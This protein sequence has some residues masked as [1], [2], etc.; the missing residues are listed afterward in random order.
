MATLTE[1]ITQELLDGL[2]DPGGLDRVLQ[3]YQ[4]SKGPL[5][6]ALAY[7][8]DGAETL[9]RSVKEEL[10]DV[11][12]GRETAQADDGRLR[13]ERT[14][15]EAELQDLESRR[16][17]AAEQL[18]ALEPT[19]TGAE[20][21]ERWGFGEA[22]LARLA[23]LLG[24]TAAEQG[25]PPEDGVAQFFETIR[26]YER[27]VSWDLEAT[28]AES[29]AVQ[30]R[31]ESQRWEAEARAR[32][33]KTKLRSASI[34][35][36]ERL[37][38]LGVKE[39]DLL[40][41]EMVMQRSGE[42]AEDVTESLERYG[43]LSVAAEE[44]EERLG[45]IKKEVAKRERQLKGLNEEREGVHAA[46]EAVRADALG[47]VRQ[48]GQQA[49]REVRNLGDRAQEYIGGLVVAAEDYGKLRGD[50][51]LLHEEL[52]IARALRSDDIAQWQALTLRDIRLLVTGAFHW[53]TAE[54]RDTA[55]RLT[56]RLRRVLG[57][58][59]YTD[60]HLSQLLAGAFLG[61]L[62]DEEWRVLAAS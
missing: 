2:D 53:A 58:P 15:L 18:Q 38:E 11:R 3:R 1:T 51:T 56:P 36:I 60:P 59:S 17:T 4:G 54:G 9:L 33:A 8:L 52:K 16:I 55:V 44:M 25:A 46:I 48:V 7:A 61:L 20:E 31:A 42:S 27:I 6:K 10:S 49:V 5:Y 47:Q 12:L 43:S 26:R 45:Q 29:R 30:M 57:F 32:E 19:L 34:D 62:P 21:L 35:A 37:S 13:Q 39:D 14:R 22:E 40:R 24:Q 50:A 23:E 41:W 28:R